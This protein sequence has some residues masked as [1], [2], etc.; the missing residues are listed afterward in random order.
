MEEMT[1]NVTKECSVEVEM[2]L[3]VETV[4]VSRGGNTIIKIINSIILLNHIKLSRLYLE[5]RR[6]T[7]FLMR[8]TIQF[9]I[10]SANGKSILI[11]RI[12]FKMWRK[13][14]A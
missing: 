8:Y 10:I 12:F 11:A 3:P 4:V 2:R 7:F 14:T 1:R 6:A 9:I 13:L 5:G